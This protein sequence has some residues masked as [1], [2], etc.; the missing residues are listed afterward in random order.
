M[1]QDSHQRPQID[2]QVAGGAYRTQRRTTLRNQRKSGQ[3]SAQIEDTSPP[4][5][6][7]IDATQSGSP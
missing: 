2:P 7:W 5:P 1:N 6:S 4:W 3:A